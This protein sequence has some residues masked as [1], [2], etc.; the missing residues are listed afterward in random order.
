MN[1]FLKWLA[2]NSLIRAQI[3]GIARHVASSL[4]GAVGLW[5]ASHG[6]DQTVTADAT[7]G[8]VL[9]L[10]AAASYGLSIWDKDNVAVKI[11]TAAATGAGS[12]QA[13]QIKQNADQA[14]ADTA[15]AAK[16]TAAVADALAAAPKT[17]AEVD[18]RLKDHSI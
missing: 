14:A 10:S 1:S 6:A 4:A 5:L 15:Q 8:L 12:E 16:T 13:A 3:L 11:D 2:G 18:Q 9:I 17:D 7:Q